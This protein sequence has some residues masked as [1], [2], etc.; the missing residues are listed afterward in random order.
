MDISYPSDQKGEK[1]IAFE[2]LFSFLEQKALEYQKDTDYERMTE[3]LA[4]F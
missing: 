1:P 2:E 4:S 3:E